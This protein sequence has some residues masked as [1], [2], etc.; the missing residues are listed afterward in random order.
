MDPPGGRIAHE[1]AR[2]HHAAHGPVEVRGIVEMPSSG[3]GR[4]NPDAMQVGQRLYDVPD[5]AGGCRRVHGYKY[6]V[7]FMPPVFLDNRRGI[8]HVG[9]GRYVFASMTRHNIIILSQR[10]FPLSCWF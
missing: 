9:I 10:F 2:H 5:S 4:R 3:C 1:T 8:V 7:V 6:F